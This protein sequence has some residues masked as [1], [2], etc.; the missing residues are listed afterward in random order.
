MTIDII[1][2]DYRKITVT[3]T[4]DALH[5]LY[6]GIADE[7]PGAHSQGATLDELMH[8]MVEVIDLVTGETLKG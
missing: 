3:V 6:V 2:V 5:H 7:L 4:Y 1:L 8:N